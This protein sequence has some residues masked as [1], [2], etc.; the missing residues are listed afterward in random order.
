MKQCLNCKSRNV[1]SMDTFGTRNYD[2]QEC[3][4]SWS[5]R[6]VR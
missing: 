3:S 5:V 2:C 4:Y 1:R 6:I